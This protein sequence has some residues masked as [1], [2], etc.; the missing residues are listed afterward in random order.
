MLTCFTDILGSVL[1]SIIDTVLLYGI[2]PTNDYNRK[3]ICNTSSANAEIGSKEPTSACFC[4]NFN[5]RPLASNLSK[6]PLTEYTVSNFRLQ[7]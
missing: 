6:Q 3:S 2:F 4:C 7:A 1:R 5:L